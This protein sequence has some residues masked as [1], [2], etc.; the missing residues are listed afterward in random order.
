MSNP[1]ST[2]P[3]EQKKMVQSVL[4]LLLHVLAA[5][6]SSVAHLRAL[7]GSLQSLMKFGVELF[8]EITGDSLQHWVRVWLTLMNSVSLS[9][10][11]IATDFQF[12]SPSRA[13]RARMLTIY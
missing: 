7:G 9:V 1:M 13:R 6:Q 3:R 2:H 4:D 11:S 8:I 10:R 12:P 5:P